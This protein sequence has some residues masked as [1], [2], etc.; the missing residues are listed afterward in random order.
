MTVD[1]YGKLSSAS[2]HSSPH[3]WFNHQVDFSAWPELLLS[4]GG[5]RPRGVQTHKDLATQ[6]GVVQI[7]QSWQRCSSAE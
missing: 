5:S 6:T 2:I 4:G 3:Q 7:E 1:K